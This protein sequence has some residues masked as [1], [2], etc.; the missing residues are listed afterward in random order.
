MR[1][2]LDDLWVGAVVPGL[3]YLTMAALTAL[4]VVV[5]VRWLG[6]DPSD[7]ERLWPD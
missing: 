3:A 4:V 2:M 7:L 5:L 6:L 1:K